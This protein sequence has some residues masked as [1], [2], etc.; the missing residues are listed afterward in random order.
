ME[1]ETEGNR[2]NGEKRLLVRR[3]LSCKGVVAS[4]R[5]R[6]QG[7]ASSLTVAKVAD[8]TERILPIIP[9]RQS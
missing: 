4:S 6:S 8:V 2:L 9:K 1:T 5:L 3:R 7:L